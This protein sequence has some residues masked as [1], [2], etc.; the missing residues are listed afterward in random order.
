MLQGWWRGHGVLDV[1]PGY[2]PKCGIVVEADGVPAAC[3]WLYLDNS[4]AMCWL[5]WVTTRP[6]LRPRA[7]L[8]ALQHL[9]AAAE[10]AAKAQH[11]SI[12]FA[13]APYKSLERFYVARGFVVNHPTVH[14]FKGVA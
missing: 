9:L 10:E 8:R 1:P 3:G 13:E 14:L 11:R 4:C 2:L 7:G 12:I 5:A 6:K